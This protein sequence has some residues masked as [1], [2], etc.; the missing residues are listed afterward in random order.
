MLRDQAGVKLSVVKH[1]HTGERHL[2]RTVKKEFLSAEEINHLRESGGRLLSEFD[3]SFLLK[4]QYSFEDKN[5]FTMVTEHF[6]G[7]ALTFYL[8]KRGG[9]LPQ[10]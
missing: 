1:R 10:D 3:H 4:T 5:S 6:S 8:D 2:M 7:E 9:P